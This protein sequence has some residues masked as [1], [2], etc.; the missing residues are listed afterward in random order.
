MAATMA[1]PGTNV[2]VLKFLQGRDIRFLVA[3]K[4]ECE[5]GKATH[6][7]YEF[8]K[9]KKGGGSL[10]KSLKWNCTK[11]LCNADGVPITRGVFVRVLIDKRSTMGSAL[12]IIIL[13]H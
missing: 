13:H 3:G 8:L 4:L 6:P 11:I 1:E 12:T 2:D 9:P 5:N 7:V 10:G